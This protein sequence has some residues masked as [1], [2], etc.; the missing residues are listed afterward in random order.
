MDWF[1]RAGG[2]VF[3]LVCIFH[4]NGCRKDSPSP[5]IPAISIIPQIQLMAVVPDSIHQL[6]DSL[7]FYLRY[8][9]GDGDLGDYSADSSSLYVTDNRFPL[10]MEYH[11]APLA[12]SG[13]AVAITGV[14]PVV[15]KHIILKNGAAAAE[16]ATFTLQLKDRAGHRSNRATTGVITILP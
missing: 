13:T 5:L 10:T 1:Y 7:V 15:L 9:D 14:L 6:S 12:P 8:T 16:A 2:S 11:I 4:W 3:L